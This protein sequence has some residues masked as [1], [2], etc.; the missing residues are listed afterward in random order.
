MNMKTTIMRNYLLALAI[1]SLSG[2]L[3]LADDIVLKKEHPT[4]YVIAEGDTLWYIASRFLR[5]PWR[6]P[7]IW[8]VNPQ[9]SNPDLI[10]PGDEVELTFK[11]GKPQLVL[12]RG[13]SKKGKL[14]TVKLSPKI[15]KQKLHKAIPTI[16]VDAIQQ[17]LSHPGVLT[18][19]EIANSASIVAFQDNR[20]ISSVG[21]IIYAQNIAPGSNPLF[22]IVRPGKVYVDTVK[23]DDIPLGIEAIYVGEARVNTF[24]KPTTMVITHSARETLLGDKLIPAKSQDAA[25]NFSPHAPKTQVTGKIISVVEGVSRI[26]QY[27]IVVINRGSKHNLEKGHVLAI[28][29]KGKVVG[30]MQLPNVPAGYLMLFRV[31]DKVSYALI[32]KASRAIRLSDLVTTP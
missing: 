13:N 32:M 8:H 24:G 9:I 12:R 1:F 22:T 15:R 20:L 28:Q 30:D 7:D 10:Y 6:W 14:R 23:G 21:N 31:F 29:Q 27:H 2:N 16:P 19:E 26:G 11:D 17:F 3:L 4:K 5:D 25:Y 18:E